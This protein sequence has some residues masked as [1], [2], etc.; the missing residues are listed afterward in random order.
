VL[1]VLAKAQ[2]P[3][4]LITTAE[5]EISLLVTEENALRVKQVMEELNQ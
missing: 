3:I 2:I 1:S 4:S 5:T